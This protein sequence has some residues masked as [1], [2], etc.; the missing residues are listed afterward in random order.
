MNVKELIEQLSKYNPEAIM[1]MGEAVPV[2]YGIEKG[3]YGV[4]AEGV[5]VGGY[6]P[7]HGTEK[8]IYWAETSCE[9]YLAKR[10]TDD[11]G[12]PR[13]TKEYLALGEECVV[14]W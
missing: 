7:L 3:V 5:G 10:L 1:I 9:G 8:D 6:Y 14:L 13:Y 4:A 2:Y 12:N 11:E